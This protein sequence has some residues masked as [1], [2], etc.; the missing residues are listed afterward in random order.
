L[1]NKNGLGSVINK[2][3]DKCKNA[4]L[5]SFTATKPNFLSSLQNIS[6]TDVASILIADNQQAK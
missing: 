3:A 2:T 6:F 4:I 5:K 1:A